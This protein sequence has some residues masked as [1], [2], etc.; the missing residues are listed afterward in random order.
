M[1]SQP[2]GL[3]LRSSK[4]EE[5]C[6]PKKKILGTLP[7]RVSSQK[8]SSDCISVAFTAIVTHTTALPTRFLYLKTMFLKIQSP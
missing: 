2:E 4:Y 3:L 6:V 1:S 5:P 8:T 7:K